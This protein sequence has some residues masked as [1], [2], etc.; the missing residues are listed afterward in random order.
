MQIKIN[1]CDLCHKEYEFNPNKK[2]GF[3][4]GIQG[5]I[6]VDEGFNFDWEE[7]GYRFKF[8]GPCGENFFKKDKPFIIDETK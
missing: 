4:N 5:A 6:K 1:K 7:S 2:F 3:S 8:C